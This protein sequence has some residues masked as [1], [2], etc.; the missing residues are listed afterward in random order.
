MAYYNPYY[1]IHQIT[2]QR[3]ETSQFWADLFRRAGLECLTMAHPDD[4]VD[5]TRLEL[6]YL[7]K[8]GS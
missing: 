4:R 8:R 6:G 7:L 5:S 2:E 3:L 1:L